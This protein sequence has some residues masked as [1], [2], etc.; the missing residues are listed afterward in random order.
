MSIDNES[1]LP[2]FR[3]EVVTSFNQQW[4]GA[5][6]LSQPLSNWLIAGVSLI[7]AGALIVFSIV[8]SVTKKA[9]TAGILIPD[10][11]SIGINARN[12]G[13]LIRSLVH[14]GDRVSA[15]QTLFELSSERH[16]SGGELTFLIEQQLFSRRQS[17]DAEQ[18]VRI[19][20]HGD[21][22]SE[23]IGRLKNQETEMLQLAQEIDLAK[24]RYNLSQESLK[25]Y[26]TL[27]AN[28]YVSPVQTQ[29][30]QE[31]LI[32]LGL[33]VSSLTRTRLQLQANRL[34]LE[35]EQA[36]L[37]NSLSTDLAQLQRAQAMLKQEVAENSNRKATFII[38]PQSGTITTITYQRGQAVN[39]GQPLATLIPQTEKFA[40]GQDGL[41]HEPTLEVHL[42]APSRTAGFVAV[43]Q[44]VQIR[45][46]A[47]PYQ[48]F[49]LQR[50][51]VTDVSK[52][53]FAPAELP[54]N[55]ASTILS[56]AQQNIAGF[57]GN[58]ALY[59]IKVKPD[60][61]TIDA[62]GK[63]QALKPGM[64]LEADVLQDKRKIWEW[65]A[66]PLL[67]ITR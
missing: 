6:R 21:K 60:R 5:I 48:K 13:V 32:D 46:Q 27:Q 49:G 55:I 9:R 39:A 64:T 41:V 29:Q 47:Y 44:I 45:Y 22:K 26:E 12:D 31:D 66:E 8:G 63:L 36:A 51:T 65:I 34:N 24:R 25:K 28:G 37:F 1:E 14:E 10:T 62:Y 15:G 54:Q 52:T 35:A 3:D 2:L 53:P 58:E 20:Q 17:L 30:K 43:G 61:Q 11:G 18:R 19:A 59:R 40:S 57:N 50:G 42:Y 16:S 56:N 23:I 33:R 67:A 4:L 7:I 38:A